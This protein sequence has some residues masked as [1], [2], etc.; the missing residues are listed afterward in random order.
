MKSLPSSHLPEHKI[1]KSFVKMYHISYLNKGG[2]KNLI[3]NDEMA[4]RK[5]LHKQTLL[6]T[7]YLPLV[8]HVFTFLQFIISGS[9]KL[10]S[11]VLLVLFKFIPLCSNGIKSQR[12]DISLKVS[13]LWRPPYPPHSTKKLS[14]KCVSLFLIS[15]L[16]V[17]FTEPARDPKRI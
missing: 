8:S 4:L 16:F 9:L 6:T 15:L 10:F 3:T 5:S 11:F 2:N 14:N 7:S 13:F 12:L 1:I 17:Y